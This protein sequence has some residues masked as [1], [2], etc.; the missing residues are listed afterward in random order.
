MSEF[1]DQIAELVVRVYGLHEVAIND[2]GGMEGLRDGALLHAA[3][4]R[5]F[6]SF[7]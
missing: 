6:A 3:V 1:A 4:A 2:S 5:P 7:D